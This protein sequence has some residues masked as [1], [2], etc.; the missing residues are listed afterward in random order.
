M[1]GDVTDDLSRVSVMPEICSR[2]Y[3]HVL[4]VA[5]LLLLQPVAAQPVRDRL[6]DTLEIAAADDGFSVLVRMTVPVRYVRH[7]PYD[8]GAELRIRIR[9]FDVGSADRE[10]LFRRETL[11][12]HGD[13]DNALA[14]VV[15]EGD[16]EGGPYLTLTFSRCVEFRVGQG[17][18]SRSILVH[19]KDVNPGRPVSTSDPAR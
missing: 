2:K 19:Y 12:P 17:R 1:T 5:G 6:L 4:L 3:C 8:S 13:D 14:E 10:A 18:D 9:P 15:Y 16:I 7:F 11:V